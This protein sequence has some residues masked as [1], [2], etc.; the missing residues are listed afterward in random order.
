VWGGVGPRLLDLELLQ[1]LLGLQRAH[2][3]LELAALHALERLGDLRRG[4]THVESPLWVVQ[5]Q[6]PILSTALERNVRPI[7]PGAGGGAGAT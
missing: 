4:G 2:A 6:H 3:H 7:R 1:A 5:A